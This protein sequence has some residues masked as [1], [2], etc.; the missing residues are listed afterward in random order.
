M[1]LH[2]STSTQSLSW[3][4]GTAIFKWWNLKRLRRIWLL[5]NRSIYCVD[6]DERARNPG[7]GYG[8][9][10]AEFREASERKLATS[11]HKNSSNK[12]FATH[13]VVQRRLS[14][15]NWNPGP[16]RG[17]EDAF[18]K[19]I[20]E[21]VAFLYL[22][23]GV[24]LTTLIT[25]F[26]KNDF[27]WS[28][29]WAVRSSSTRTPSTLTSVSSP[30]TFMTQDESYP[31]K[32][33]K[34][35][36]DGFYKGFFHVPRFVDHQS[37]AR[38]SSQCSLFIS[39]TFTPK[40]KALPRSSFSLFVPSWFLKKLS[41]LQVISMV[42]R[43]YVAPETTSVLL[44]KH[45]LRHRAPH[46][47]GDLD[48]FR[49]IGQTSADCSNHM[50]LNVFG[51]CIGMVHFPFHGNRLVYVPPIKAAI[52]KP[53]FTDWSKLGPSKVRVNNAFPWKNETY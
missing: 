47:C 26:F 33:W 53:G 3:A 2:S 28:I 24:C 20:A 7:S 52:T 30:S 36:R 42:L 49:T 19:Q 27:T 43:G 10:T 9:A 41:W 29:L 23:R 37:A 15:Y 50:A 6:Q 51:K 48:P 21:K 14:I 11:S 1:Q 32:S 38:S 44:T 45:C 12:H 25:I 40:R 34:E 4:S 18:E 13:S 35:N 31:I 46:N 39:A 17:K 16:R 8:W 22:A 5:R